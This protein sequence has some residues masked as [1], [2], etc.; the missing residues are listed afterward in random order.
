[1]SH[2]P[3]ARELIPVAAQRFTALVHG[4]PDDKWASQTP[5]TDWTTRDLVNHL[6]AE[7][8]WAPHLLRG[9]TV[10]EVGSRYD[11][12]VIGDEP[13]SKWDHAIA[14]SL[15]AFAK[16]SDDE[17]V[18]LS[19]GTVPVSE[20]A[21]QMLSDLTVHAWDLA[22]GSGQNDRLDPDTV[23]AT[24]AYA[25]RNVDTFAGSGLFDRPVETDSADPQDRMLALLG[26]NP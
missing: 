2:Q 4:V 18:N 16:V 24:L 17:P 21:S 20:Y 10:D 26:R 8:L 25:E 1:M 13:V 19:F 15:V 9:E 22:R 5:C 14:E 7:H 23:A 3:T 11:G 12:D 6:V